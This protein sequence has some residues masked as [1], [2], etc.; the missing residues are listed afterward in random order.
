MRLYK[1]GIV[2]IEALLYVGKIVGIETVIPYIGK[3]HMYVL[4]VV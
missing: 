1:S 3:A 4:R 2:D